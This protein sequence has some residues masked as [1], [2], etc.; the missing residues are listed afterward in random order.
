MK[1]RFLKLKLSGLYEKVEN[2]PKKE[3]NLLLKS[4]YEEATDLSEGEKQRHALYQIIPDE[5]TAD[6]EPIAEYDI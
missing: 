3:N 6:L 2:L 4:I 1:L 5:P